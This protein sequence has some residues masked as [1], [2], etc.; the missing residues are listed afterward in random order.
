M[1]QI[2]DLF[3]STSSPLPPKHPSSHILIAGLGG[4]IAIT[5]LAILDGS[6]EAT[7][8]LGSFGASCVLIFGFPEVPFSQPRNIIAGHVLS[9]FVGLLF[10]TLFGP[11]WW[12]LALAAGVAIAVMMATRTVHPPA[13]SNPVIIFLGQ[14]AW[15]FLI[16]PTLTGAI[17]LVVVSW[18][19]LRLCK[20]APYPSYWW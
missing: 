11:V 8:L 18:I 5:S 19:F 3:K 1:P 2:Q 7:L 9:S 16:F 4:V 6:L 14:P 15:D 10:L 17:L 13:G 12:A 20:R